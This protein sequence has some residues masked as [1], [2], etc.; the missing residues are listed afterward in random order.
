MRA[1]MKP[2]DAELREFLLGRMPSEHAS[3]LEE[4]IVLEDE[5]AESLRAAEFDLIDDYAADRL[6]PTDR[7]DMERSVLTTAENRDTLRIALSLHRERSEHAAP[8]FPPS[9]AHN[10]TGARV[11][12]VGAAGGLLAAGIVAG[13]LIPHWR[14]LPILAPPPLASSSPATAPTP[15]AAPPIV[16][17]LAET[18]RG[19]HRPTLHWPAKLSLIRLQAEVPTAS[20]DD[21]TYRLEVSDVDGKTLFTSDA[22]PTMTAGPYRFVDVAVPTSALG[23]GPRRITLRSALEPRQE[24]PLFTWEVTRALD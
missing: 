7:A 21:E 22:S 18:T 20:S 11:G 10:F 8:P 17:L 23:P 13:I 3:R 9:S 14:N 12:L 15:D 4:A 1:M 6:S 19:T 16:T 2:S 24:Q 5:V